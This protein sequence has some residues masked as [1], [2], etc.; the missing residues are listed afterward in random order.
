MEAMRFLPVLSSALLLGSFA[1]SGGDDLTEQ[2][3][4]KLVSIKVDDVRTLMPGERVELKAVG[5]YDDASTKDISND[6]AWVSSNPVVATIA[7]R[8]L[9]VLAPGTSEI[10]ASLGEMNSQAVTFTA[11]PVRIQDILL[12]S[13]EVMLNRGETANLTA[14]LK[15]SNN[16]E[17]EGT[18]RVTWASS[19]PAA[20]SVDATGLVTAEAGGE[21]M[22]TASFE[23]F[24]TSTFV[25]SQCYYP[26]DAGDVIDFGEKMPL[27]YWANAFD[28]EGRPLEF[29]LEQ[30]YCSPEYK[31]VSALI[32][33]ISATW[34]PNCPAYMRNV[35]ENLPLIESAG[36]RL[37]F[38]EVQDAAGYPAD[39]AEGKEWLDRTIGAPFAITVGDK[40][41]EPNPGFWG[42]SPLLVAFPS[43]LV[44]RTSDMK[45]IAD[46][47]RSNYMLPF[48]TIARHTDVDWSNPDTVEINNCLEDTEELSEPNNR[49]AQAGELE[50]GVALS[51]GLCDSEKDYFEIKVEGEYKVTLDFDAGLGDLN[52]Y[53]WDDVANKILEVDGVKVGSYGD[54]G[55]E[56]FNHSGPSILRIEGRAGSTAPYT[57][58]VESL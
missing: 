18:T 22:I 56:E 46:Q 39:S 13:Y 41:V 44:V 11:E 57:L 17:E 32:F 29:S 16:T 1:C 48:A 37:I 9:T 19:N 31:D 6:V 2:S 15:W 33:L 35:H 3:A 50:A 58:K 8:M 30:A 10:R 23:G 36:A 21:A 7:G 38:V 12:S 52:M 5:T 26:G 45:V 47:M 20:I 27:M 28:K 54:S 40:D 4:A 14:T 55:H 24:T 49:P 51:G 25:Y 53:I 34:C 43:A 42:R